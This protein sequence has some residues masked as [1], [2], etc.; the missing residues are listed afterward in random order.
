MEFK[1]TNGSQMEDKDL[2]DVRGVSLQNAM[3]NM[4]IGIFMSLFVWTS[5]L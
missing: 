1:E 2:E 3:K 5:L 4:A